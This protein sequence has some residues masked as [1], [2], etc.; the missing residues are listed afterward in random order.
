MAVQQQE[1]SFAE[2]LGQLK[3]VD[4]KL[5]E[6]KVLVE[7]EDSR[8]AQ[9]ERQLEWLTGKQEVE[10]LRR[11][12]GLEEE[13]TELNELW[14]QMRRPVA[15]E[16]LRQELQRTQQQLRDTRPETLS[17]RQVARRNYV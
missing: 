15:L 5:L 8:A 10:E 4:Q 12:E 13:A 9:Q 1:E 17:A 14:R 11:H 7:E 16:G 3:E 6:A 2:E